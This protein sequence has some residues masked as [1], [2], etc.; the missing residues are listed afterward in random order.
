MPW[1]SAAV[2]VPSG[3]ME[4]SESSER[5]KVRASLVSTTGV[6]LYSAV[7]LIF[8]VAPGATERMDRSA[9]SLVMESTTWTSSTPEAEPSSVDTVMV[10]SWVPAAAVKTPSSDTVPISPSTA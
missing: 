1:V 8:V 9:V 2:K 5:S 6:P 4:P 10:P 3:A 7:K